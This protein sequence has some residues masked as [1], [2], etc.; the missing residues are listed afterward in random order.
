MKTDSIALIYFSPTSTT[1]QV[2]EYIAQGMAPTK[3]EH[4]DLTLPASEPPEEGLAVSVDA[5]LLGVPV[6]A[7]RVPPLAAKRLEKIQGRDIPAVLVAVYGNRAYED[8]LLELKDLSSKQGFVPVAGGAFIGEHSFAD[9]DTPIANGRPDDSDA[10]EARSFGVK[11]QDILSAAVSVQDLED[12]QVPGNAPYKE[13]PELKKTAPQADPETC[14]LCGTCAE[15]C[16]SGAISI[17]DAVQADPETCIL[18]HACVKNC[19]T[20]AIAF[21]APHL[22]EMAEKLSREHAARKEPEIYLATCR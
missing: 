6:Y 14:I 5:V 12:L 13:R 22:Q 11:I 15:S 9:Q 3:V 4:L 18:C 1:K 10:A 19:P 20:S 16:P 8:A 21:H 7:G 2:L 17:N